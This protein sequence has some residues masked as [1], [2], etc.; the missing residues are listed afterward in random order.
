MKLPAD[1]VARLR[2]KYQGRSVCVTGGAGF[3]GGHLCDALLSLGASISV[4]DDLSNSTAEHI[5]SLIDL[6]PKRIRFYHASVLDDDALIEAIGRGA[7]GDGCQI[8]FHLAAVG[9]VPKSIAHPQRTWS[10]NATGTVRVLVASGG[11][12]P[13]RPEGSGGTSGLREFIIGLW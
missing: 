2:A 5:A 8:V 6:E 12:P 1:V 7:T 9:S 4:I 13:D 3:I 10:V 11:Q